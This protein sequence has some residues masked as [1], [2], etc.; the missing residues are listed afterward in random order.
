MSVFSVSSG[1]AATYN[2][3]ARCYYGGS[4]NAHYAD[5]TMTIVIQDTCSSPSYSPTT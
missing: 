2:L 5:H 1:D 3:K 4:Y